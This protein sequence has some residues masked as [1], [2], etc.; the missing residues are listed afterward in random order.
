MQLIIGYNKKIYISTT[1]ITNVV[2]VRNS[3]YDQ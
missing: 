3:Y 1:G 2:Q